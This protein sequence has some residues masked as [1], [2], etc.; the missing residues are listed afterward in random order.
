MQPN[1]DLNLLSTYY[2]YAESLRK[3]IL[4]DKNEQEIGHLIF[5]DLD[6]GVINSTRG[7]IESPWV[8]ILFLEYIFLDT[9]LHLYCRSMMAFEVAQDEYA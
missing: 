2:N 6:S 5:F 9:V 7:Y 4:Q 8:F 1:H 3:L